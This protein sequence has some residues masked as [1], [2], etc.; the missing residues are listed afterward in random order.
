MRGKSWEA[1]GYQPLSLP[2]FWSS[3]TV[4]PQTKGKV[5][6]QHFCTQRAPSPTVFS[7]LV[8][9][10]TD[11]LGVGKSAPC[12]YPP[13][14]ATATLGG[15]VPR[16]FHTGDKPILSIGRDDKQTGMLPTPAWS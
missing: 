13:G 9:S 11:L 5:G 4:E 2:A 10:T 6:S 14:Q 8:A 12:T 7:S 3:G 16:N 15:R 1:G